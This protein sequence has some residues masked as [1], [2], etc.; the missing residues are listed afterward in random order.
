MC[1]N[2]KRLSLLCY[3]LPLL[4]YAQEE[5]AKTREATSSYIEAAVIAPL[6]YGDNFLSEG[7]TTA[8]GLEVGAVFQFENSIT[9]HFD[10]NYSRPEISNTSLI[11][12]IESTN[13][14]RISGGIGYAIPLSSK[15]T[16]L[17]ALNVGYVKL[18]HQQDEDRFRDDGFFIAPEVQLN[19]KLLKSWELYLGVKH[20]FDFYS[21]NAPQP[22]QDF[23]N[24]ASAIAPIIGVRLKVG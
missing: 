23:F 21:I 10:I 13:T 15:I 6:Y 12:E 24:D 2:F 1:W 22:I 14:T 16:F 17:P 3:L 7:Y 19:I 4:S 20:Y 5:D 11:G 9:A 18:G 8:L